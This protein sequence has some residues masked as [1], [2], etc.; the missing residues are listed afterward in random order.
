MRGRKDLE[1]VDRSGFTTID[2]HGFFAGLTELPRSRRTQNGGCTKMLI[3]TP[4]DRDET[5]ASRQF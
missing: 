1:V 4:P 5:E 3:V 2:L